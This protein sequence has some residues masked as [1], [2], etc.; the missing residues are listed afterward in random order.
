MLPRRLDSLG[1]RLC[2]LEV[3]GWVLA[4][5][6]AIFVSLSMLGIVQDP[7]VEG[8]GDSQKVLNREKP[9]Q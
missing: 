7:T 3:R 4:L 1:G 5:T 2:K 8:I 9:C 6:N